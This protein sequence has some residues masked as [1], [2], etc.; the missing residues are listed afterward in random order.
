MKEQPIP[1]QMPTESEQQPQKGTKETVEDSA[2]QKLSF[3]QRL[4]RKQ[5]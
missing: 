2:Q 3:F 1:S 4:F 5:S